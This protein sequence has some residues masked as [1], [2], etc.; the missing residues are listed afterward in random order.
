MD[1]AGEHGRE[2]RMSRISA[3]SALDQEDENWQP[4]SVVSPILPSTPIAP[5]IHHKVQTGSST[6][7]VRPSTEKQHATKHIDATW[8]PYTL[9]GYLIWIPTAVSF[10]LGLVVILLWWYSDNHN[11]LSAESSA[12]LGWKFVPT[13]MAVVYTQLTTMLFDD[14]KRTEPFARLGI[15]DGQIPS[16]SQ[17]ILDTPRLW[18]IALKHGFN[19]N[20]NGGRLSWMVILSCIVNV[21]A[22]MV[23]APLSSA[24]LN[25]QEINISKPFEMTRLIPKRD[26]ALNPV[27]ERDTYFRTTGAL[28]QNISTSPWISDEYAVLPFWPSN[29]SGASWDR[30]A[31]PVPQMWQAETA[32]FKTDFQCSQLQVAATEV[33]N[34]STTESLNFS[35]SIRLDTGGCQYNITYNSTS[36]YITSTL[37]WASIDSFTKLDAKDDNFRPYYNENCQ[38]DEVIFLSTKWLE[39]DGSIAPK[40]NPRLFSNMKVNSYM[41]STNYNMAIVPVT[42]S[43]SEN[44]FKVAFDTELFRKYQQVVPEK[45]LNR[46]QYQQLY[47]SPKWYQ[48]VAS[49]SIVTSNT[50]SGFGGPSA[51]LAA[52]YEFNETKMLAATTLPEKAGRIR[53]RHFGELLRTSLEFPDASQTEIVSGHR[54]TA[55]R[56]IT[57]KMELAATVAALL[58]LSSF[59][60]LYITWISRLSRRPLNLVHDPATVLGCTTLVASNKSLLSSLHGLDQATQHELELA[61]HSRQYFTTPGQLHESGGLGQPAVL[62]IPSQESSKD[63][64]PVPLILRFWT[65]SGLFVYI[66]A[67]LIT[68]AVLHKFANENFLHQALFTYR[69]RLN[70]IGVFV[71]FSIIPTAFGIVLGL[72][73]NGLDKAMRTLQ[74]LVSMSKSPTE[75]RHGAAVS[76]QSSHWLWAAVKAAKNK[77]WLLSLVT[78]GTFAAQALVIAM[79]ALFQQDVG[80]LTDPINLERTLE[81]R[82]T[83]HLRQ[84]N[85]SYP[86]SFANSAWGYDFV[87]TALEDLF[88]NLTTNWMYTAEIQLTMNGSEPAWSNDGWSFVPVD[89]SQLDNKTQIQNDT[90]PDSNFAAAYYSPVNVTLNTPAIRGR[91]ECEPIEEV[92]DAKTW[93]EVRK[94]TDKETNTTSNFTI[95]KYTMFPQTPYYNSLAPDGRNIQCC[96]NQTEPDRMDNFSMSVAVGYW[97]EIKNLTNMNGS[98]TGGSSNFTVK[99]IHGEGG[100]DNVMGGSNYLMFSRPPRMQA[101][102]CMPVMETSEAEIVVDKESGRVESYRLL[103]DPVPD[104]SAWSDS[105]VIHNLTEP[106]DPTVKAQIARANKTTSVSQNMTTSYGIY[107][108]N[109]LLR[110]S[111]LTSLSSGALLHGS[112]IY[113]QLNDNV[114]NIRNNHTGLNLDFMSYASYMQV[115]KD[116]ASLLDADVLLEQTQKTFTTFFQHHV[117]STLSLKDGGWAFQPIGTNLNGIGI[118]VKGTPQQ[119]APNGKPAVPVSQLPALNTQR[120][121]NATMTTRVE[122]LRM[123]RIAFIIC[124]TLLGWLTIT[125]MVV[126]ALEKWYFGDL[127]RNVECIADVLV[128]VAGSEKLLA[129]VREKGVDGLKGQD[130]KTRLGPFRDAEGKMRWGIEVV[131]DGEV[132]MK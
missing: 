47:T 39:D 18:W 131:E 112:M 17:T 92:K 57:V 61:L 64:S 103:K 73:W 111:R 77:H 65:L 13:L 86:P 84:I 15:R 5:N 123:N 72:W 66:A 7:S 110:A 94:Y 104:D 8:L 107:F 32:V 130:I 10:I 25:A 51:L 128:L 22:F 125:I 50:S 122:V 118:A 102:S 2:R 14:V 62:D 29:T 129:L 4:R 41:C 97:T 58:L 101:L 59:M 68:I 93:S 116:A 1:D 108:L 54:T 9:R 40:P 60:L 45:L 46:S 11:G 33:R 63:P 52:Q 48:Y 79:S 19:R 91:V 85:T 28:L 76:Y 74:P 44:A 34:T 88:S 113:E 117:S 114:F 96:F 132:L 75:M 16:A 83:P 55:E 42:A 70:A 90:D 31:V 35:P 38:G 105:F 27:M 126:A 109:A 71:P 106:I 36:L 43:M 81:L 120:Q 49:P 115:N 124:M 127:R 100:I 24:L 69:V 37:S 82:Q 21:L 121:F 56:R 119:I 95:P 53:Q 87:A 78:F 99:W 20:R 3:V 80:Y 26:S 6:S 89:L 30:R 12:V 98:I 23:I 67:L